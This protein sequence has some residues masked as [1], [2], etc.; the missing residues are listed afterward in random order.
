MSASPPQEPKKIKFET[1][2]D[3]ESNIDSLPWQTERAVWRTILVHR[4]AKIETEN[5][6]L[7]KK[8]RDYTLWTESLVP[9]VRFLFDKEGKTCRKCPKPLEERWDLY[10]C[11]T[12]KISRIIIGCRDNCH[13]DLRD[14]PC[15]R[16][17]GIMTFESAKS[18]N[19]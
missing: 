12:C 2:T 6:E 18:F 7:K 1:E 17:G 9:R 11:K 4:I 8:V 3:R 14:E 19:F 13:A 10:Y 15:S 5:E 16:C